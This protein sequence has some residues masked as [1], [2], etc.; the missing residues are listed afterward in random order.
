MHIVLVRYLSLDDNLLVNVSILLQNLSSNLN[1]LNNLSQALVAT[2]V[3]AIATV[4]DA[5]SATIDMVGYPLRYKGRFYIY[6]DKDLH[7]RSVGLEGPV[8]ST[9]N[10]CIGAARHHSSVDRDHS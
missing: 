10:D 8:C 6:A 3:A 4:G 2:T 9:P 1:F 5:A 7:R